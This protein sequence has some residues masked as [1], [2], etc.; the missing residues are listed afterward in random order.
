MIELIG[1]ILC[2]S[3]LFFIFRMYPKFKIDT[4]QA[5]V[6]NYFTA[7]I[8]GSLV[9]GTIP[10]IGELIEQN[11]LIWVLISGALFIS[12]FISMGISSQINGMGT[13]SVAVKMSLALS[14]IV[15]IVLYQEALTWIKIVG[16]LIAI[17]GILLITIEKTNNS[18]SQINYGLLLFLFVGSAG[19]DVVLN[20][21]QE[22]FLSHYP[23]SLFTAFGFLAAGTIGSIWLLFEIYRK[24]RVFAWRNVLAGIVLGIP[25]YFSIY[26]L[27]RAYSTTGWSNS[28][29]LAVMNISIVSLAAIFG[30]LIFKESARWQ[31]IVGLVSVAVAIV[32]LTLKLQS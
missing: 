17:A 26:F 21:V 23:A 10:S 25:N 6:F 9:S 32:C 4:A 8:C 2:S 1:T 20:V 14:A 5:I 24:K 19:L 12:L 18:S 7:F 22:R 16:F 30:I 28:T 11:L 3:I 15:F 27:V 13:T 29:V 31:R